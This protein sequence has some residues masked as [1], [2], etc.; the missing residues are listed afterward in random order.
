METAHEIELAAH[1]TVKAGL[2]AE[3][4][5]SSLAWCW[6]REKSKNEIINKTK[7]FQSY[8][9]TTS[10]PKFRSCTSSFRDRQRHNSGLGFTILSSAMF[11]LAHHLLKQK[12]C[13]P[14]KRRERGRIGV[15]EYVWSEF[16]G[17]VEAD[18]FG[19]SGHFYCDL[20]AAD[21]IHQE[22]FLKYWSHFSSLL[23]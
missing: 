8:A 14:G 7:L 17:W 23:Q 3:L 12:Q 1:G 20:L 11:H 6:S 2:T 4:C 9:R 18:Y 5:I 13:L 21:G 16:S 22:T 15:Y 10:W 19:C